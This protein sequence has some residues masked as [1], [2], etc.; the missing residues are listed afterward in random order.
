MQPRT[1][2]SKK[3]RSCFRRQSDKDSRKAR[4]VLAVAVPVSGRIVVILHNII[5]DL[6]GIFLSKNWIVIGT[7]R[8]LVSPEKWDLK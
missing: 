1:N 5:W 4:E 3:T 7:A 2:L 6:K 8:S